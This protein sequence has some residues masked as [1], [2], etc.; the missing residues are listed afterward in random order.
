MGT[1]MNLWL[2]SDSDGRALAIRDHILSLLRQHGAVQIQRDAV[3]LTELRMGAWAFRHW[4]PFNELGGEEASSP[5]YRHAM[6]RQRT[7]KACP[8]GWT[9][10]MAR[11]GEGAPHLVGGRRSDRSGELRPRSL[12]RGG[13]YA[14]SRAIRTC[15]PDLNELRATMADAIYRVVHREDDSFAVE[16]TRSGVLPQ[17]AVGFATEAEA[18]DWIAQ[19]KRLWQ[20]A[21]PFRTP[22]SRKWR[23]F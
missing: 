19:D 3:R 17:T 6:E 21:D 13:P 14:Y 5:G 12:G 2:I 15:I 20:A 16:I 22:A 9:F 8:M 1:S 23:G 10:G 4:T 11:T 7:G 18:T